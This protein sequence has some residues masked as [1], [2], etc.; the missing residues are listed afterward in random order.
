[1]NIFKKTSLTITFFVFYNIIVYAQKRENEFVSDSSIYKIGSNWLTASVGLGYNLNLRIQETNA[2]FS[3]QYQ[4]KKSNICMQVGYHLTSDEFFLNRSLQKCNDIHLGAGWRKETIMNDFAFFIGPSYAYG[5]SFAHYYIGTEKAYKGFKTVGL[6]S[7]LQFTY[8]LFYDVGL[9]ICIY[10][11]LNKSYQVAGVQ[12]H[13]Y[14]SGA[15]KG[16]IKK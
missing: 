4:T 10:Y 13:L 15:Y 6:F 3:Y 8:K 2:D 9:G 12:F 16:K 11:S 5:S 14:F 7:D 1:V